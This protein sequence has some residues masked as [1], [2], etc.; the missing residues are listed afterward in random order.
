MTNT[1]IDLF[2]GA[3]G[4]TL[5]L[6]EAGFDVL[7]GLDNWYP[8][9]ESYRA[10][11]E[12]PIV[13]EDVRE[14]MA[15]E[16]WDAVSSEEE[17]VDLVAG[18]PPCQGFSIQRIG[19][20]RDRRNHLIF[21]FAR[22]VTELEPRVFLMENVTGLLGKRGRP[23][24]AEFERM[25]AEAGFRARPT[26]LNAADY[27]V[28]QSRSRVFYLGWR[29]EEHQSYHLPGPTH[30]PSEHRSVWEA[31]GDLPSPPGDHTPHPDD[32]LHRRTRLSD[33]NLKRLE[34]IPPGG[35]FEDIPV[36]LRADCHKDGADRIGHRNVYGRLAP[37]EPAGTITARF[38]SFTRG[39]FAHPV[40]DRNISLREGA[41]LQ[42]F[43]DDFVFLGTQEE[44]AALIGNAVPPRLATVLGEGLLR[45]LE[46]DSLASC[47]SPEDS[48]RSENDQIPLFAR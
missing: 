21:E 34:H 18:G 6:Q 13:E 35:G 1:A 28:P 16:I 12:H 45:Q 7:A 20:D 39:Q 5:G 48:I 42:T 24:A 33:T 23:F 14:L 36:A 19:E 37:D 9:V 8:A 38:D 3:G 31:I 44:V 11:F 4:L 32:E 2:C 27:G 10:N 47:A 22:L 26:V 46:G 29:H 30:A 43:P 40:E 17:Q 25:L 15:E 41:R